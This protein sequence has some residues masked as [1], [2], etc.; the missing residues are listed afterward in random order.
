MAQRLGR[1]FVLHPVFGFLIDQRLCAR[2][3]ALSGIALYNRNVRL[4][5]FDRN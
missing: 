5:C 2:V 3:H 1:T 4:Q